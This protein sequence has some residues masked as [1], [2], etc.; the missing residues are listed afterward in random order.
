MKTKHDIQLPQGVCANLNDNDFDIMIKVALSLEAL[1][2]NAI[3][4][5]WKNVIT[6]QVLKTLYKKM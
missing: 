1:W 5:D 4:K 3:G 6:P 2:E